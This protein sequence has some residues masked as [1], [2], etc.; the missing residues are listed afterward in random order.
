MESKNL[1][2]SVFDTDCFDKLMRQAWNI[3]S[4]IKNMNSRPGKGKEPENDGE[5]EEGD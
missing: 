5:G 4:A 2:I 1:E 3:K